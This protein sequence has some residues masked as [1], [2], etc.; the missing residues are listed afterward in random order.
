[1]KNSE[2]ARAFREGNSEEK[3]QHLFIEGNVI[4][5]YG[6]HFPIAI[7]LNN[8]TILFN[9]DGYSNTTAHHKGLVKRSFSDWD[10][11]EKNT[12]ELKALIGIH[13]I[14]ELHLNELSRGQK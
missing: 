1:M 10:I 3:T 2:V 9:S 8:R 4:Y 11:I 13:T 12:R 5:S 14:E 6:Y 7:K